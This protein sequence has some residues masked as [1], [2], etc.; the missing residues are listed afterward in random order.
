MSTNLAP[1]QPH[2]S[3]HGTATTP[4]QQQHHTGLPTFHDTYIRHNWHF[5]FP[6]T[7]T[8]AALLRTQVAHMVIDPQ[9]VISS[10][11]C[12]TWFTVDHDIGDPLSK[13][14]L[15]TGVSGHGLG[16]HNGGRGHH[17]SLGGVGSQPHLLGKHKVLH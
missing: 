10:T 2:A 14:G 5:L 6:P 11:D 8:K 3:P 9:V 1:A 4:A 15:S 13:A 17:C 7:T 12:T 16:S